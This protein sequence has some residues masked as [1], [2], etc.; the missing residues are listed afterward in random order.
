MNKTVIG[1]MYIN[2][3]YVGGQSAKK[4]L[5]SSEARKG[6]NWFLNVLIHYSTSP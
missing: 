6:F 5:A 3:Y 1:D 4:L 2:I